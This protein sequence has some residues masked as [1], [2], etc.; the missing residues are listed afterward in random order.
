MPAPATAVGQGLAPAS[1][2]QAPAAAPV[3]AP[4]AKMNSVQFDL[5]FSGLDCAALMAAQSRL[6]A[7]ITA[8]ENGLLAAIGDSRLTRSHVVTKVW[9]Q[10]AG[11]RLQTQSGAVKSSSVVHAEAASAPLAAV[12]AGLQGALDNGALAQSVESHV[13]GMPGVAEVQLSG[14]VARV[15]DMSAVEVRSDLVTTSTT[16]PCGWEICVETSGAKMPPRLV[17][18]AFVST[19]AM[20]LP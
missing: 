4:S 11:R 2:P 16:S 15:G 14:A 13:Q 17:A 10:G 8:V 7:F 18:A 6:T 1:Q 12:R 20:L 19:A 5:T 9:C 3:S